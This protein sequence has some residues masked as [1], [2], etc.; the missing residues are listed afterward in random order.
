MEFIVKRSS[1]YSS[2][3]PKPCEEAYL[4]KLTF[5]DIRG[6]DDPS[7]IPAGQGETEW[8]YSEGTNHRLID[9][10]IARDLEQKDIWCISIN[11][12]EELMA[13][14]SKYKNDVIISTDSYGF[15]NMPSIEIY[16][17]YRE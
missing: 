4:K 16:D 13:F 10:E 12:L 11:S 1:L 14:Q 8:W 2:E 9:N 7:K 3:N 6:T 15:P 17:D 5:V